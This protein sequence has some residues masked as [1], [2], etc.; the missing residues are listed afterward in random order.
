MDLNGTDL[1]G[2]LL[3]RYINET[4]NQKERAQVDDWLTEDETNNDTLLQITRIY[5]ACCT[6]QNIRQ[7]DAQKALYKVQ[8]LMVQRARRIVIRRLAVAAS[9]LFGI[10][11]IGSMI[12]QSRQAD[13]PA[14]MI[15]VTTNAGMRSQ[16]TLPDGTLVTLN[17][18][19][20]LVYPSHYEKHERRVRLS[21]EAYFQVAHK[22]GQTFI[23]SA[24]DDKVQVSVKGTEFNVQAYDKD[25]LAQVTLIEG[26]V[27]VNIEGKS[28]NVCLSPAER[29]TFNLLTDKV[30]LEKINTAQETAWMDGR[31]VFK[32]TPVPEVLRKL[33]RFYS[34]NFEVKDEV[35]YGYALTGTFEDRPLF[36]ILD[37]MK[38]SSKIEYAMLYPEPQEGGKPLVRLSKKN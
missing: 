32:D 12:W 14:Q 11:G 27:Q 4:A 13:T 29:F 23:V 5:H 33:S 18:G 17:A 2:T 21:G 37:Y 26:S 31:L 25:T 24:A 38:I 6:R 9:F 3:L 34:V 16:A 20:T 1:D 8:Q 10:L 19:S 30:T 22:D 35:I 28:G 7:R 36:Q 15:T